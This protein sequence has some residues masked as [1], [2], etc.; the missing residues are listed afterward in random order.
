MAMLTTSFPYWVAAS[1]TPPTRLRPPLAL[2]LLGLELDDLV[3]DRLVE[4]LAL[5]ELALDLPAA[6]GALPDDL[7][8][9]GPRRGELLRPRPDLVAGATDGLDDGDVLG[10]DPLHRVDPVEEVVEA[11]RAE[12][13]FGHAVVA[14]RPVEGDGTVGA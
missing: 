3:L 9:L 1:P 4:T 2:A 5:V 8:L 12:E 10:G 13:D 7:A 6:A 11:R 14:T